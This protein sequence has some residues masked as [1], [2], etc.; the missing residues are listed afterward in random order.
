MEIVC[1][2]D[3]TFDISASVDGSAFVMYVTSVELT[4]SGIGEQ[5]EVAFP[6][7]VKQ[8]YEEHFSA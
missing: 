7:D 1:N 4:V 8:S 6:D 2:E 3:G 5:K